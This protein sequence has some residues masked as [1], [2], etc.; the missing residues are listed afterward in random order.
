[1]NDTAYHSLLAKYWCDNALNV[2]QTG[3]LFIV[4]PS[5]M[6]CKVTDLLNLC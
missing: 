3:L 4:A 1:M 2:K 6:V 5:V